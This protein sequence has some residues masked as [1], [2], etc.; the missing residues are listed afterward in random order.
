MIIGSNSI[1]AI[2]KAKICA[3]TRETED[4]ARQTSMNDHKSLCSSMGEEG[5]REKKQTELLCG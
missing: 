4:K 3:I 1:A 2:R 5:Q